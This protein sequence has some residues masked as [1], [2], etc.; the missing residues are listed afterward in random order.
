MKKYGKCCL[1]LVMVTCVILGLA[2]CAE[3]ELLSEVPKD[4]SVSNVVE[5]SVPSEESIGTEQF[6][7]ETETEELNPVGTEGLKETK[8]SETEAEETKSSETAEAK[9]SEEETG[10]CYSILNETEQLWYRNIKKALFEDKKVQLSKKGLSAGMDEEDIDRIYNCVMNDY[11]ELFYVEGYQYGLYTQGETTIAIEFSGTIPL[12]DEERAQK[13]TEIDQKVEIL[14]AGISENA[15]DYD[16]VKYV[17]ETVINHTDY[18]LDA[19]DNQNMYS[20]FVN[21]KSVCIGYAKASQYLLKELGVD[22]TLVRGKVNGQTH[23]WNLVK[24][25]GEYYYFD[26]TWGDASYFTNIQAQENLN[27]FISY[28]YLCITTEQLLKT[29]HPD[30]TVP[31]PDC[32]ATSANY[33]VR[34]SMVFT[35]FDRD[36]IAGMIQTAKNTGAGEITIKCMSAECLAEMKRILLEEQVIFELLGISDGTLS[37]NCN[38]EQLSLTIWLP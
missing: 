37:Y 31:M 15:S 13:K 28:D 14:L 6:V 25:D 9:T 3:E 8:P 19:P 2:G 34:E 10:Y 38:E 7:P 30:E 5:S 18:V 20:V 16:K 33:Y 22:C 12:S 36:R 27:Y 11:P 32:T 1:L 4:F 21:G 24:I 26:T 23:A 35:E 29:H 17:Y